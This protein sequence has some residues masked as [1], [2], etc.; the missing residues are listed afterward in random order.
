MR[1]AIAMFV[2]LTLGVSLWADSSLMRPSK[3]QNTEIRFPDQRPSDRTETYELYMIDSYGDGWNGASLDLYVN[4]V[5]VLDDVSVSDNESE[6]SATFDVD[7]FDYLST[8]WTQG[9]FDG[10]CAYAVYNAA[11]D[12]VAEAGTAGNPDLTLD[13]YVDLTPPVLVLAAV[14]DLTVSEGGSSGKGLLLHALEDIA[15]LST[16]GVGSANNGGG[17]DGEEFTLP[18]QSMAAGDR[19]WVV[20]DA[21][22]YSNYFGADVW[23]TMTYVVDEGGDAVAQNGDDAIE[24]FHDGAVVDVFGF[25][26]VDGTGETWEYTDAWAHRSCSAREPSTT[27]NETDW[28]IAAPNCTDDDGTWSN[29]SCPFPY[30]D[31]ESAPCDDTEY[32]VTVDGGSWQSEVTWSVTDADGAEVLAGAAPITV[33]DNV[34]ACM[35]DG[36]YTLHMFD[37]YGDG[38][39]GNYFTLWTYDGTDYTQFFTATLEG[40]AEGTATIVVGTTNE[41]FGCTD[42][43]A[44]NYNPDATLDDGSCYYQG[45]SCNIALDYVA[46]GGTLDGSA[47]L[48]GATVAAGDVDWYTMTLDAAWENLMVSLSGS[49]FDTYLEVYSDCGTLVAANDDFD[50]V[51][52]QVDLTDVAA[53]TYHCMVAGYGTSYGSYTLTV[54]AYMNPTNPTNLSAL[55]GLNR[56]YLS[57][58]ASEP[59]SSTNGTSGGTGDFNGT[60]DE[61]VQWMY[62]NKKQSVDANTYR[63]RSREA[64]V[65]EMQNSG[66]QTRDTDVIVTLFDSY[67]DGHYGGDSDGD[68]YVTDAD[69]N[70]LHTLAGPW[71]GASASFGPFTLADGTYSVEWDAT[72]PWLSEQTMQVVLASDTNVVVGE[73]AAPSACFALGEGNSCSEA[74]LTVDNVVYDA[75]TGRATVTVTNIGG[76]DAGYFYTMAFIQDPDTTQQYPPGYFQ[77]AWEGTGLAAGATAEFY[78]SSYLTLPGFVGGYDDET[79]TIYAMADGYGNYVMEASEGNNVGSTTVVN[80]NPLGNSSWNVWRDGTTVASVTF[81]DWQPGLPILYTDE[82][83]PADVE[84]CYMVTQVD[85]GTETDASNE[86]CATPSAP[87]DVP[88]PSNLQGTSS[89]FDVT[90]TWDAPEPYD[91]GAALFYGTPS[92]TRQ[93]GEDIENATVITELEQL[94]GTTAGYADDYDEVCPYVGGGATDVVYSFTPTTDVA[95]NMTTCYSSFDTKLY[96][97][98]N[99]AG[100]LAVTTTGADACSDD[101]YPPGVDD[102]TAWTSYIEGVMMTAG[103]TYYLVVDGWGSSQGDYIVDI[104][105]YDP[106]AGYTIWSLDDA[107]TPSPVGQAGPTVTEW[108]TVLFAAEPTDLDLAITANYNIPGIFDPVVSDVVGPVTVTVQVED[109]PN[110]LVA[111]DYGDDVHL[112]WDPPI[113]ASNMELAYDDG[114]VANAYY[115]GGAVAVRFRV[116]GTYAI[117]GLANTVWTGGW[118]DAVLGEQPYTLSVLALDTATDLPGDTLFSEAVLV[119][120]DPTSETYGWAMTSGL[121]DNPLTVTGDVFVMYSDFGYDFDN[122]APG[123][124]MDMMGC[125]AVRDFPGNQ[126]E[127]IGAPGTAEWALSANTGGFAG[128]GDWIFHMFADFSVGGGN[129]SFG[130]NG[131]WIDQSGSPSIADLP[132]TY[133]MMEAANTKENP[134]QLTNA[135]SS[136]PTWPHE[137]IDRDMLHYNIY[138][139][140]VVVGDQAPGVHDYMDMGLDWGTYTYHVTAMYDDHESIATNSVEVTLSNVAPDAVMLIS[141]GDGLEIDV[142]MDNMEEEVAFI[143]TAANDPDNDPVEYWLVAEAMV[144]MDT[145]LNVLPETPMENESFEDATMQDNGWQY[146]PDFW[147][148]YPHQNNQTVVFDG[149]TLYNSTETFVAY[150]GVA[151]VKLWGLYEGDNTENNIFQTWY[152][153]MLAPGTHFTAEA[154][155]MSHVDDFIGQGNNSFILFAKYF[156]ADW[157]WLGMDASEPLTGEHAASEWHHLMVDCHVP[158]GASTVQVGA[159]LVQP[160]GDDHG[161]VYMD[162]FYMHVPMM[163]TGVFATYGDLAG[164]AME[165]GVTNLTWT[166][167]VWSSDGFEY[168]PSS[169]GPR[170]ITVDVS[171]VLGIDGANLPKEFALHNNYPNPFNPVTNIVYDIPEVTDVTLEIYNVMG[172]RVRTLAQGSHEAGRYQIVWNA[173]NDFGQALSSGMYIYRIQAGDFVSVKKLVLMKQSRSNELDMKRGPF[174]GPL[175]YFMYI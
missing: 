82:D 105:V 172:Q 91:G 149:E 154:H 8:T 167:D 171:E 175:F 93:G 54:N 90:L 77:Y 138:R 27:F 67:G 12:L 142:T 97:Y 143:W 168:V 109:S 164:A 99:T 116:N 157:G 4:G 75:W 162:D 112:M 87:P 76:L 84:Y 73:G 40:G 136:D 72:A 57:W 74:D 1:K 156:T 96:V 174:T 85:N 19:L 81:P 62:D 144:D 108:N 106:L 63:G 160:T 94:T 42:A 159:M 53:G 107:G 120:A 6:A 5:V 52:S 89:G 125:D 80:S 114:T 118:P 33:A 34:L 135:P 2:V 43:T 31:C 117:N 134:L 119:D 29:S 173:T 98:E 65:E 122:N 15:D 69:G 26:D 92:S 25:Q 39:N 163:T 129:T 28:T 101:T 49:Q 155:V 139:D 24:L 131:T 113:D 145:L 70:V 140:G 37:S 38:W 123:A 58:E 121:A 9:N 44:L 18:A 153:G 104:S 13:F 21:D 46:L 147:E 124:D 150:D 110:N 3:S 127:Y 83:L 78:L 146:L 95:V 36:V 17:T 22:A 48:E 56:V 111:Q 35:A 71:T 128:C 30:W 161:S 10:E 158:E 60:A 20:R 103:N 55:G 141:P 7:D 88:E 148:G 51:T 66:T 47:P 133:A 61:H 152:D 166:W 11:G 115:Y 59:A 41:V 170:T 14:L 50:G 45:D 23:A 130:D 151:A 165:Y 169:S 126:Y 68:A 137:T 16:Y 32:T 64:V 132:P 100:N 79:Y 102:C 86:S